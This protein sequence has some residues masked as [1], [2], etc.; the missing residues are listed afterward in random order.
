[1]QEPS[2]ELGTASRQHRS[3]EN[4]GCGLMLRVSE[5]GELVVDGL[6]AGGPADK[7]G[8]LRLGDT[9]VRVDR[10][11]VHGLQ[12]SQIAPKILGPAGS[13]VELGFKRSQ[14]PVVLTVNVA[15]VRG[16]S[17]FPSSLTDSHARRALPDA[18]GPAS[19]RAPAFLPPPPHGVSGTPP[20]SSLGGGGGG[21][22]GRG[23]GVDAAGVAR[24]GGASLDLSGMSGL[25]AS[26]GLHGGG[27]LSQR[28]AAAGGGN[29][30]QREGV[31]PPI[32]DTART[33]N[34][35]YTSGSP[36]A[37]A[38]QRRNP[39]GGGEGLQ[40]AGGGG[41][42]ER[43]GGERGYGSESL[44]GKSGRRTGRIES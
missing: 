10:Q 28:E 6:L 37:D 36:S 13:I 33:S 5:E 16:L 22:G 7:T 11:Y 43:G 44:E 26:A 40:R 8:K 3:L 14:G 9:L 25:M 19:A 21:A 23:A 2:E 24:W 32:N 27:H 35:S 18:G 38:V 30:T 4:C 41:G 17:P 29:L 34:F 42:G 31:N 20:A 12:P 15:I 1:M 39:W